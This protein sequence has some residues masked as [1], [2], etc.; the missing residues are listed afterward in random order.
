M[1]NVNNWCSRVK[2]IL[3]KIDMSECYDAKSKVD[4]D[5]AKDRLKEVYSQLETENS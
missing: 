3:S 5:T 1:N 2:V 4:I